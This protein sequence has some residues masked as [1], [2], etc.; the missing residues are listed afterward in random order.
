ML[1]PCGDTQKPSHEG[2]E[3]HSDTVIRDANHPGRGVGKV[4]TKNDDLRRVGVIRVLHQFDE[5]R[6]FP[7]HEQLSQ[8]TEEMC[9]NAETGRAGGS[10]V[11]RRSTR[12]L[13][14][15]DPR[16]D[17]CCSSFAFGYREKIFGLSSEK[18]RIEVLAPKSPL[19]PNLETGDLSLLGHGV[20]GLV[21]DLQ[22][23]SYLGDR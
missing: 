4:L 8:F 16:C 20:D 6:R 23:V 13:S 7:A 1:H 2:V 18:S 22:Q 5:S 3:V 21:G 11:G 9:V 12:C 15:V 14:H 19:T 10:A 17:A